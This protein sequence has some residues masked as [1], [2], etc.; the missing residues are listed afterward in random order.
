MWSTNGYEVVK[1]DLATQTGAKVTSFYNQVVA[2][3]IPYR[4]NELIMLGGN[5]SFTPKIL[6]TKEVK[7]T[8]IS[9]NLKNYVF[10]YHD[11]LIDMGSF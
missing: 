5:T 4:E 3:L 1:Y 6:N 11:T 7:T 2:R 9:T 10:N 8:T